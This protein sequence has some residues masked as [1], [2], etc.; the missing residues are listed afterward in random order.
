MSLLYEAES[1]SCLPLDTVLDGLVVAPDPFVV[2]LVRGTSAHLDEIDALIG[3]HARGWSLERMPVV[4]RSLL[5]LAT[6]ELVH[7][8]DVPVGAVI[9]EAVELAKQFSTDDSGRFVNGVLGQ[10]AAA[11]RTGV[12]PPAGWPGTATVTP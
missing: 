1:R 12:D 3:H 9:S 10:I 8:G 5:R 7:R 2:D 4:D 11:V 6:Y